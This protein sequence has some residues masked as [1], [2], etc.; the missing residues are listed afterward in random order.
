MSVMEFRG[1]LNSYKICR[2]GI[3]KIISVGKFSGN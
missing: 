3:S 1:Y 2:A